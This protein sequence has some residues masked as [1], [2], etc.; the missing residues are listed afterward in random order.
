MPSEPYAG[1]WNLLYSTI[2][3]FWVL[4]EP[5]I[6]AAAELQ[7]VPLELYYYGELGLDVFSVR[8]FQERDPYS[9]PAQY[10][11]V[12]SKLVQGEWIIPAGND[13]YRVTENAR[14]AARSII[15]AGDDFLETLEVWS[16]QD[17]ARLNELLQRIVQANQVAGEPPT[18]WATVK[19]FRAAD[20][21][22]PLLAQIREA[23][24]DLFAY[25]DDSHRTA[26]RTFPAD[27]LVWNTFGMLWNNTA[28]TPADMARQ[29][30]FRGYAMEDYERACD[31]LV[32]RGWAARAERADTFVLTPIGKKLRDA[33]EQLT[34]AY[35]YVPWAILQNDELDELLS[36]QRQL[37]ERLEAVA[38][39]VP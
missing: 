2:R 33:V 21:A 19:R 32:A 29:A 3:A 30:A 7:D 14:T 11:D 1:V 8:N 20:E 15:R 5:R 17:L 34:D 31:T 24:L 39:N 27:G 13:E 35:F 36:R 22:S 18:K 12:F 16:A 4:V 38:L 9:N 37:R 6:H 23:L 28:D 10:A 26:W 25:R